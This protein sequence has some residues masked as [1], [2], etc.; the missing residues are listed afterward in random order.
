[1]R[2]SG[3]NIDRKTFY[4]AL[5]VPAGA[6]VICELQLPKTPSSSLL[7]TINL[8]LNAL[9]LELEPGK[10]NYIGDYR[11]SPKSFVDLV[12]NSILITDTPLVYLNALEPESKIVKHLQQGIYQMFVSTYSYACG[13]KT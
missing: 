7:Q 8:E 2:R 12:G 3:V 4:Y 10:V 1:M 5:R 6:H 11:I 9:Y 13:S